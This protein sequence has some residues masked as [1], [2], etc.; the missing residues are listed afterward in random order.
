[1]FTY[2]EADPPLGGYNIEKLKEEAKA[3]YPDI[4][5]VNIYGEGETLKLRAYVPTETNVTGEQW[6]AVV[7]NH[8][9]DLTPEQE[10]INNIRVQKEE[11]IAKSK[12]LF[13]GLSSL[14]L[15][16][17]MY[18]AWG[19]AYAEFNGATQVEID[20]IVDR[21]T[22]GDYITAS[23]RWTNLTV[24]ERQW[25]IAQIEATLRVLRAIYKISV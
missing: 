19:R 8:T 18:A 12:V 9:P 17:A 16:D 24:A 14:A 7:D 13:S 5:D 22:A 11:A 10:V 15:D 25:A 6:Q 20:A 21:S 23:S 1:M 2:R 3:V 4:F